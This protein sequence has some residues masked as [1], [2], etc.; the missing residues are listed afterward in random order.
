MRCL[1]GWVRGRWS[2]Y[3]HRNARR[4][5]LVML[6]LLDD[7]TLREI[8]LTRSDAEAA[9]FGSPADRVRA[10]HLCWRG[11]RRTER[12]KPAHFARL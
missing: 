12:E 2:A 11:E 7:R 6:P 9:V 10:Y 5:A 3:W 1:G 4:A 8:G